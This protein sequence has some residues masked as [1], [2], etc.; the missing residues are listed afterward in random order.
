MKYYYFP[1]PD[2]MTVPC[3]SCGEPM[4]FMKGEKTRE[5][6]DCEVRELRLL[7]EY[8]IMTRKVTSV[9]F[10]GEEV[11]FIDHSAVYCPHP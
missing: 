7:G 1:V 6:L 3:F 4:T 9:K 8:V 5:C 10:F 11:E 2:E